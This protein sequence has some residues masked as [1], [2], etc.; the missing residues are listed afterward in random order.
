M[1]RIISLSGIA[2]LCFVGALS[3]AAADTTLRMWTFLDPAKPGGR[4]QALKTI[5]DAFEKANPGIK[6]KVEPQVW[7]TLAE[8]FVLGSNSGQAP[9]VSWVNAEN[10]GLVLSS[11]VAADLSGRVLA[12]WPPE[13]KNDLVMPKA[14]DAVTVDG[15]VL[16]VPIMASTWVMMYRKDLFAKA[17]IDVKSIA[18]WEGVT[19]AAKKLTQDT[20]GDG[21]QDIWGIGLGL[22]QERFSATPAPLAAYEAQGGFFGKDC[23]ANI[24]GKGSEQ[25][26]ALQASWIT[27]HKVAPREALSMTSDDAIDQFSAGRYAMEIVANSRFEQIQRNAAGWDKND[28]GQAP[29]PGWTKDKPGPMLVS[30]WFA[31][32]SNKSP[33]V[34]IAAKFVDYMTS[35]AAMA[36]WNIPG[37]QVPMMKS[38]AARPE[39][40]EAKNAPL[41]D[42]AGFMATAGEFPPGLCNWARTF[43]DFNLATQQVVLGQESVTRAVEQAAKATQDRQ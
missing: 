9:D 3:T 35:P 28:L 21:A 34:E 33:H 15:Q 25:A 16:A 1:K 27:E 26:V 24:A 40:S 11:D 39:M 32:V 10:L 41:K 19:E 13:R 20:N 42:V 31:V 23:K 2:C 12:K 14:F 18:T 37:G 7:T 29:I 8:K 38:V 36:L 22:A 17:G 5:I 4:E 30:G 6:I 43:A